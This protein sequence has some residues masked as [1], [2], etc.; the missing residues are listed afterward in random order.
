MDRREIFVDKHIQSVQSRILEIGP[1]NRPLA[2]RAKYPHAYTADIRSTQEVWDLYSGNDYLKATGISVDRDTIVDIDFV[3]GKT[4]EETFHGI[5]GFDVFIASHVL[6]HVEDLISVF[7]DIPHALKEGA[8]LLI[9]WPEKRYCFDHFRESASFRDAYDVY[10]RGFSENARMVFDFFNTVIP[11][12]NPAV[13][14]HSKDTTS[15]LPEGN[16]EKAV[17]QYNSTLEGEKP[18]DV[19]YWPFSQR[20]FLKF[21]YDATRARL[22]PYELIDFE[23]CAQDDQQFMIALQYKPDV[24]NT[25]ESALQRIREQISALPV[26]Y[27]DTEFNALREEKDALAEEKASLEKEL[28]QVRV[29][30]DELMAERARLAEHHSQTA[31]LAVRQHEM[32]DALLSESQMLGAQLQQVRSDK[33]MQQAYYENSRSWKITKPMRKIMKVLRGKK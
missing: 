11:E 27:S 14:W 9:I 32:I 22:F 23:P 19:H 10:R 26:T 24:L 29:Q 1:L 21:I 3:L 8:L 2:P 13:F 18:D 12:N 25:Q 16:V 7:L 20:A 28:N 30:M 5:E 31:L 15:L 4:Y 6:E 33:N 17:E